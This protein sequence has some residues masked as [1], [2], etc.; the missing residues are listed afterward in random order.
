MSDADH[1]TPIRDVRTCR[2]KQD[3][4]I[5]NLWGMVDTVTR[6]CADLRSDLEAL[7]ERVKQLEDRIP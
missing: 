2:E 3:A 5:D 4:A 1:L 6:R 7:Q